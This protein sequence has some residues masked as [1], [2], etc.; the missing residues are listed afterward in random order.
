MHEAESHRPSLWAEQL[1]HD[2]QV[3]HSLTKSRVMDKGEMWTKM[4]AC[5]WP[6][7][8]ECPSLA[9]LWHLTES[10]STF[11]RRGLLKNL[12]I[13]EKKRIAACQ[14]VCSWLAHVRC[15]KQKEWMSWNEKQQI[16]QGIGAMFNINLGVEGQQLFGLAAW[17]LNVTLTLWILQ[18]FLWTDCDPNSS[19]MSIIQLL[20]EII[21][22]F[23]YIFLYAFYCAYSV[24]FMCITLNIFS[25]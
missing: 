3:F 8:G 16:N 19:G 14:T 21:C 20:F 10:S 11:N 13:Q 12:L 5:G 1:P 6:N 25:W 9:R 17:I 22:I 15:V 24:L 23:Y 18:Y 7:E 4:L 2:Q